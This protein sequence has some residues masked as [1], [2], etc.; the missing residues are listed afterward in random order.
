M[1]RFVKFC[2]YAV[3]GVVVVVAAAVLVI[4]LVVDPNDYRE[5]IAG[6]IQ[7]RTGRAVS[8][9]GD[10][11]V[12]VLPWLGVE[13][14][15]VSMANPDG[16][17]DAPFAS[18]RSADVR[19]KLLPLLSR[20]V[21][22]DTVVVRG[23]ALNLERNGDGRSN[24]DDLTGGSG[25]ASGSAAP[26]KAGTPSPA[27]AAFALGG[28][29]L[30]DASIRYR[31]GAVSREVAITALS[32][33]TG[34]IDLDA[35]VDAELRFDYAYQGDGQS[36]QGNAEGRGAVALALLQR[37]VD[38]SGLDLRVSTRAPAL[39]GD[40]IGAHLTGALRYDDGLRQVSSQGLVL[41][42]DAPAPNAAGLGPLALRAE[43]DLDLRLNENTLAMPRLVLKTPSLQRDGV[44]ASVDASTTLVM[45]LQTRRFALKDL[46]AS[47]ALTRG[48][49]QAS[50]PYRL[51][52]DVT[53]DLAAQRADLVGLS[54]RIG[55]LE[56]AGEVKVTGLLG[57]PG[58]TGAINTAPFDARAL[59]PTLGVVLP[60]MRDP[61]ALRSVALES[62]FSFDGKAIA[63][64]PLKLN[65]DG[66][67]L[68]GRIASPDLA[69][70]ALRFSLSGDRLDVDRYLPAGKGAAPPSAAGAIPVQMLRGLDVVGDIEL[71]AVRYSGLDLSKVKVGIEA[72]RSVLALSPL[73]AGLAG[74]SYSGNVRVDASKQ[75]PVISIDERIAN[76]DL[77]SVLQAL[78]VPSSRIDLRGG[79]SDVALKAALTASADGKQISARGV[80]LT[81]K[82]GGK[83]LPGGSLPLAFSGDLDVDLAASRLS[84]RSMTA[85]VSNLKASGQVD[86]ANFRGTPSYDA[87]LSVPG[88]DLRTL[89]RRFGLPVPRTGSS[90]A[91]TSVAFNGDIKGDGNGIAAGPM[92]MKLDGSTVKGQARV[93]NFAD[94]SV[95]FDLEVDS[96][97]ADDYLPPKVQGKAATPGAAAMVLPVDLVRALKLNGTLKVSSLRISGMK[98]S[99]VTLT[100]KAGDGKLTLSPLGAGLYGGRY[101]GNITLDARQAPPRLSLNEAIKG[102]EVGALLRD[103]R[104]ESP[105]TGRTDLTAVLSARG[106]DTATLLRTMDGDVSFRINEG[107]LERIDMVNSMCGTLA[108][109]DFDRINKKTL[110]A[111]AIGLLLNSMAEPKQGQAAAA[112]SGSTRFTTLSGS[113]R[114]DKGVARNE[115][116][117]LASPVVRVTGAGTVD[118]PRQQIDYDANAELVQ[119]CAGIGKRDLAGHLIP[120]KVSGPLSK[121][122][123]QPTIP[124]SLIK[125]V[126]RRRSEQPPAAASAPAAPSAPAAASD[127][128]VPLGQPAPPPQQA[129][130]ELPRKR[131][132]VIK[133][134]R[135]N[136]LKGI[137]GNIL[138]SD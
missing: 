102:V 56:A 48:G 120:V 59:L 92:T 89:A 37:R 68:R 137:L 41:E 12:S 27:L 51:G 107:T 36:L 96:L 9:E 117:D 123:V 10:L 132:H 17:G 18:L 5:E 79:R 106:G 133:D 54:A 76:M 6:Q 49:E 94:P 130:P 114:I 121:P 99:G 43:A 131:G 80:S 14:G 134:A 103:L 29:T 7:Q 84:L 85:A 46:Q 45:N 2:L 136:L 75:Q 87:R 122:K 61:E 93:Q 15:A 95:A 81:A 88:F 110:A 108:A 58:V 32:A 65:L 38:L 63:L 100:A 8:I 60:S 50:T 35:P 126:T 109:F 42:L 82:L 98:L 135:D 74:G 52:G 72:Q 66:A 22:M 20:E 104:G 113:A 112:G 13:T 78:G 21:R 119:A 70:R 40:A 24:W 11:R 129:Q 83:S 30:E 4:P 127:Q 57:T 91:F 62:G 118:L 55:D 16:F 19:V 71:D 90:K 101:D 23:L 124:A 47:G 53:V 128:G 26:S 39:A 1:K 44:Q 86:V 69:T 3:I 67:S 34:P 33:R 28:V 73:S 105:V 31:D 138:K 125:A 77:A 116:L 111:G 97:D 25:E 115:D 64:E